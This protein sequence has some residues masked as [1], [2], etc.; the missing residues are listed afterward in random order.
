MTRNP[1]LKDTPFSYIYHMP[2]SYSCEETIRL[3]GKL[4]KEIKKREPEYSGLIDRYLEMPY[5]VFYERK[6]YCFEGTLRGNE[7]KYTDFY[8]PSPDAAKDTYGQYLQRADSLRL[9]GREVILLK[10]NKV[11]NKIEV[12]LTDFAPEYPFLIQFF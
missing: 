5:L 3:A 8:F 7:I 10:R 12:G 1:F 4:R 2:C 6:F 9:Q 11:L